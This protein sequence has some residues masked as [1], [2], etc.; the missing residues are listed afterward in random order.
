MS[1]SEP[2]P[3]ANAQLELGRSQ[4]IKLEE[5]MA[6]LNKLLGGIRG[7]T[8][9]PDIV[10]IVDPHEEDLAVAE[11]RRLEIP[12][13]ALVDTNCNPEV[14]DWAIPANDDAIR[15]V[16]L[17]TS[18]IADAVLEGVALRQALSAEASGPVEVP[19]VEMP[20]EAQPVAAPAAPTAIEPAIVPAAPEM[21]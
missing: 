15:A 6:N 13:V 21:Q 9:L 3:V 1:L 5:E 12:I 8:K 18:K 14:I 2:L 10:Y 16:K 19:I 4:V 11:A 17:L 20:A 7:I